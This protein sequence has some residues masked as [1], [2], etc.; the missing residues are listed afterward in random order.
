MSVF[1]QRFPSIVDLER[2]AYTAMRPQI[3]K[4]RE[5]YCSFQTKYRTHHEQFT[6][7]RKSYYLIECAWCQRRIRWQ[8][9]DPSVPGAISHGICRPC[10]SRI[11]TQL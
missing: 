8:R 2:G 3:E 10:A 9:K 6:T 1:V 5:I 11:L 4:L 7:L